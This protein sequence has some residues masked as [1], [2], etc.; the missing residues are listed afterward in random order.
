[1]ASKVQSSVVEPLHASHFG[2]GAR[3]C[4]DSSPDD[5]LTMKNEFMSEGLIQIKVN[6]CRELREELKLSGRERRGRVFLDPSACVT[7]AS[8]RGKLHGF[9]R[10]LRR[11]SYIIRACPPVVSEDGNALPPEVVDESNS[12]TISSDA[13]VLALIAQAQ[14]LYETDYKD[15]LNRPTM[16][17]RIDLNPN[18]PKP[19]PV[20]EYLQNLPDPAES[21]HMTMLSFYAFPACGIDDP[22]AFAKHLRK[23]WGTPFQA[24][25]RIYVAREGVNAQMAVPSNLLD[26]FVASCHDLPNGVGEYLAKECLGVNLDPIPLTRAEFATAGVNDGPPFHNLHVRVRP[27]VVSDGLLDENGDETV[28]SKYNWNDAGYDMPPEEWHNALQRKNDD[29]I[30]L[31]CRNK[32]ESDVGRFEGSEPLN[33]DTFKD[34]WDALKERLQEKPKDAP[35]YTYCTGGIRCVK[36]GAYLT[37]ELGF[38]NVNR[39]AGGI[40][41]YDRTVNKGDNA[42]SLFKGTNFVFD[43]RL[44]RPITNEQLGT[45]YTCG[46]ATSLVT[47]CRNS[48]CHQ[49]IVQCAKCDTNYFGTCSNACHQRVMRMQ[50]ASSS[51]SGDEEVD[52]NNNS[53]DSGDSVEMEG[54][55]INATAASTV[56]TASCSQQQFSTL[57]EYSAAYSSPVP[58]IYPELMFNTASLIPTGSHMVSGPAVGRFLQ[59]MV[60]LQRPP[61]RILEVGTF[62]GYATAWMWEGLFAADSTTSS[63]SS[64][65]VK[66]PYLLSMERDPKAFG[67]AA[68]HLKC[69]EQY[70]CGEAA[71][72]A[73]CALRSAPNNPRT[74]FYSS[75]SEQQQQ[76]ARLLF[77]RD[78]STCELWKVTD[79][80]ATLESSTQDDIEE[81][82]DMIF[83]DADK[84]RMVEYMEVFLSTD[85]LLR[86]GGIVIVDNVLWKG[87]VLD[88][89]AGGAVVYALEQEAMVDESLR[90]N[91]R[92]R[93]LANKMH[94]FNTAMANDTRVEVLVL[95]V[96]DGL[97]V[98]RKK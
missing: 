65:S 89:A 10:A 54:P 60:R 40:I 68:E 23:T 85:R 45:C 91:R 86:R 26:Q 61:A 41:A 56:S 12:V 7:L 52:N 90:Q 79:A 57:E 63:S 87:L 80:L 34:T 43:G 71:A 4:F 33:T 51:S 11:D 96:R 14:S 18:R 46:A 73:I 95:P 49:R 3:R 1:M 93:K 6:V 28:K 66:E 22:E 81:P 2:T 15:R 69:I 72:E 19:P 67:V 5:L 55:R 42:S 36:V 84:T 27:Q 82:F 97:S 47:N 37:Q 53:F 38:T 70:G 35:I 39:L 25:G 92:A 16:C 17:L 75:S 94:R 13:D 77:R 59:N 30:L 44:G 83:L 31:D 74:M 20:P 8:L 9:F 32:Y 78:G 88:A 24:V 76:V 62:S 58:A 29:I 98:I 64:T 48:N 21:S 50:E